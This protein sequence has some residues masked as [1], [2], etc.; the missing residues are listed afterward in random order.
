MFSIWTA[1]GFLAETMFNL[2]STTSVDLPQDKKS[3]KKGN[4][5]KRATAKFWGGNRTPSFQT[6]MKN[7][8]FSRV[9]MNDIKRNGKIG[10]ERHGGTKRWVWE[11]K[12]TQMKPSIAGQP[13]QMFTTFGLNQR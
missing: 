12:L 2:A 9:K 10:H 7:R 8:K 3:S 4:T 11:K 1:N 13:F 5:E 6:S